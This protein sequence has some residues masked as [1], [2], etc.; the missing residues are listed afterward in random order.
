MKKWYDRASGY[1]C[2]SNKCLKGE[3]CSSDLA[4]SHTLA[5]YPDMQIENT[6]FK[7]L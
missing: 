7:T 6:R 1:G 4:V 5:K 2:L 3:Q